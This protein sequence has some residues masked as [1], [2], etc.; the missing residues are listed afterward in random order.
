ME[1]VRVLLKDRRFLVHLGPR[2][3]V[4][5]RIHHVLKV[6]SRAVELLSILLEHARCIR[7]VKAEKAFV[8][9]LES[10]AVADSRVNSL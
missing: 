6:G 7:N 8:I 5:G 4:S 1:C 9:S 2:S 10:S 3:L